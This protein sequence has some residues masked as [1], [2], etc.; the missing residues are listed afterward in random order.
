MKEIRK[1]SA[2][3][4]GATSWLDSR[5]TFSF[6]NY[7]D[8]DHMGFRSLRVINEDWI[9]PAAGFGSHPHRDMEILTYPITGALEHRDSEGNV[10]TLRP[11]YVQL[12]RAGSGIVHSEMNPLADQTTHLLQIW[13]EPDARGLLPGYQE[14][15]LELTPGVIVPIASRDGLAGGLDIHQDV[16]ITATK[17]GGGDRINH[18]LSPDRHAWIQVVSGNGEVSDF[19]VEAGD[20]VS[21]SD[22]NGLLV[23]SEEGMEVLIFDLV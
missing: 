11:G 18:P 1:S 14:T 17:L 5:H 7:F 12:M 2:R 4:G 22:E 19:N 23:Q 10:S 16:T 15:E 20:G 9:A 3:G 6:A 13:I 21:V 8:R